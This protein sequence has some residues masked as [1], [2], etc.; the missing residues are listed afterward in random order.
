MPGPWIVLVLNGF[1]FNYTGTIRTMTKHSPLTLAVA[2][3][4]M[5]SHALAQQTTAIA[6]RPKPSA[7]GVLA[8]WKVCRVAFSESG[9]VHEIHVAPG[10]FVKVGQKL[11]SLDIDQQVILVE[12]AKVQ[13]EATGKLDSARAEVELNRRKLAAIE[14]GRQ[15]NFTTQTELERAQVE[16]RI[17]EGK[18]ANEL[19]QAQVEQLNLKKLQTQLNQRTVFAP[20]SGTVVRI[21]KEV[22]EFVAPTSPEVLEIVDTSRLRAT[23]YL[24][25]SEVRTLNSVGKAAI[26]VD[27]QQ[28]AAELE[29]VAP[30]ADGE[31]G[32]IEVRLVVDNPNRQVIGSS[33]TLVLSASEATASSL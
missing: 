32:L 16:L 19:N 30:V 33:C 22:G 20:I 29:Y 21:L 13:A 26:D 6:Q 27:G 25:A 23:F 11:A 3:L 2:A 8:P 12:M 4:L 15:K 17:S 9:L 24:A 1:S 14:A 10:A 7:Q 31:S 18:L 5:C 28:V